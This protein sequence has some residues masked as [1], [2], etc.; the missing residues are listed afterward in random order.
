VEGSQPAPDAREPAA[1]AV[2]HASPLA[3][4]V[5]G[6]SGVGKGTLINKL[7]EDFPGKFGFSVSHTSRSPRPGEIDG[8]HYH[9]SD[10]DTMKSMIAAGAFL[11]HAEVHGN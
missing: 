2:P 5:A 7:M 3:V 4:V 10:V 6:P 8:V 9:F 11:E 1:A